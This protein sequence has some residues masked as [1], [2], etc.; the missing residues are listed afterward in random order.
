MNI[1]M[2]YGETKVAFQLPDHQVKRTLEIAD[3][4]I[5]ENQAEAIR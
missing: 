3:T 2:K 5:L 1:S 4:P